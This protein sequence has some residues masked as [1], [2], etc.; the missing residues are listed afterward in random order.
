MGSY[1][2]AVKEVK[3]FLNRTMLMTNNGKYRSLQTEENKV[4]KLDLFS[5]GTNAYAFEKVF[6]WG[7]PM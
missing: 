6:P 7:N 2:P 5:I 1:V 3:L 4:P